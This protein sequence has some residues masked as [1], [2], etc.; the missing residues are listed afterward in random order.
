MKVRGYSLYDPPPHAGVD[1]SRESLDPAQACQ[2]ADQSFKE[3]ADINVIMERAARTG[4][5]PV[6]VFGD[7]V[8]VSGLP[9]DF[10][11]AQLLVKDA[12]ARFAS[13]PAKL[14]SR[15]ANDPYELLSFIGNP[16]N[17]A[18]A[19]ELGLVDSKPAEAPKEPEAG[20]GK[21]GTAAPAQ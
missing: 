6:G 5:M 1:C 7:F 18:E 8:D 16:D 14:R 15:F 4:E 2:G 11:E 12:E 19:R 20:V 10:M 17:L 9:Q 21:A 3:D 13:L